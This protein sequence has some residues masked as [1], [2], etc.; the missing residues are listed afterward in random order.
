[1]QR[2]LYG[3]SRSPFELTLERVEQGDSRIVVEGIDWFFSPVSYV[4]R[5]WRLGD[6]RLQRWLSHQCVVI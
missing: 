2:V 1:M 4:R 5:L 6:A 3:E